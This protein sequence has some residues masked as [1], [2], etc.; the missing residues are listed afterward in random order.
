MPSPRRRE[1]TKSRRFGPECI[2]SPHNPLELSA[3]QINGLAGNM[4]VP[5]RAI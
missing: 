2:D 4:H 5:E 3:E 1:G